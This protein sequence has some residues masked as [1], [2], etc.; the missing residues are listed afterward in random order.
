L[1]PRRILPAALTFLALAAL[2]VAP[3]LASSRGDDSP[4]CFGKPATIIAKP[5]K[6]RQSFQ[7]IQG[8]EGNDVIVAK[9][10]YVEGLGGDDLICGSRLT[11][12]LK[13]GDGN[14][15][16]WGGD[17][18]NVDDTINGGSGNDFLKGNDDLNGGAG[19]DHLVQSDSE[20]GGAGD[21][22]LE[23]ES[24]PCCLGSGLEGGSGD[25]V[26]V[27]GHDEQALFGEGGNDKVTGGAHADLLYG[28]K[29]NDDLSGRGGDD[30][31][32]GGAGDD[33]CAGDGGTDDAV[34][35]EEVQS[36]P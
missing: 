2:L 11:D 18:H 9:G 22:L 31:L 24:F 17:D 35:C 15:R 28:G 13:G 20:N 5:T 29:G 21:D 12:F 27:A 6:K 34:D 3:Q 33:G 14:D 26:L 30:S 4:T 7:V 36:V 10:V 8:T 23:G 25:D 32:D 1:S 16:I 19:S